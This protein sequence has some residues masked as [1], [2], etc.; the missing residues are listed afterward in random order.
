MPTRD[1]LSPA[2]IQR[3]LRWNILAGLLGTFWIAMALTMPLT[4]FLEAL[5]A[6]GKQLGLSATLQQVAMAVQIPAALWVDR[7]SRRKPFWAG[8]AIAHRAVWFL[9]PL[10]LLL[11]RISPATLIASTLAMVAVSSALGHMTVPAWFAWMADLVP[12]KLS[13][14]FWGLRQSITTAAF[15]VAMPLTGWM[16]DAHSGLTGFAWCFGIGALLGV[17]DIFVHLA[18][19]EPRPLLPAQTTPL[20]ERLRRPF[21]N[22]D[23]LFCTL[24][25]GV[26]AFGIGLH[27]S[28]APVYLRRSFDVDYRYLVLL[29]V[30]GALSTVLCGIPIGKAID[31]F[32]ARGLAM[33]FFVL[34]PLL[35]SAWF[36]V[37]PGS[38]NIAGFTLPLPLVIIF[39]GN[40]IAGGVYAGLGLC[41]IHLVNTL[42]EKSGRAMSMALHWSTV[43]AM[44][45]F[46]PLCGGGLLDL[47]TSR[48]WNFTLPWG[49]DFSY[50]QALLLLN[51]LLAVGVVIPLLSQVHIR[52]GGFPAI[53]FWLL[54]RPGNIFRPIFAF[55]HG[56]INTRKEDDTP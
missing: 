8:L 4:L 2:Q 13:G 23:F 19:P 52:A 26:W 28:F 22:R 25:F 11:P 29:P 12:P 33:L 24:A 39:C 20:A 7:L 45:A 35:A 40:F 54:L 46:G 32:G 36:F 9:P 56:W 6:S 50:F 21:R 27:A 37:L 47:W 55:G 44:A 3:G 31:R 51:L 42:T 49:G 10:L 30:A 14:R 16:L 18:V 38:V 15:I 53:K 48:G 17:V 1:N 34:G 5:G 43:G 41:Q